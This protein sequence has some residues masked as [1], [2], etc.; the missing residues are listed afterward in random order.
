MQLISAICLL[1]VRRSTCQISILILSAI[2]TDIS[3]IFPISVPFYLVLPFFFLLIAA[4]SV[5]SLNQLLFATIVSV[6]QVAKG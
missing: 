1:S 6:L 4:I 5:L 2:L 3:P